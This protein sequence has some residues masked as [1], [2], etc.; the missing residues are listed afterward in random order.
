MKI[1]TAG[2]E[3][4]HTDG[5]TEKTMIIIDFRKFANAPKEV[6]NNIMII[7][8]VTTCRFVE[9][10]QLYVERETCCELF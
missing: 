5:Q 7:R 8:H 3:L 4:I 1:R 6:Q 2:A 10:C 9:G